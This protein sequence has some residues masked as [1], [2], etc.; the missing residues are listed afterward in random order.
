M[1]NKVL[2][3]GASGGL[4]R[5]VFQ[6]FQARY[7]TVGLC[8]S[9]T[10]GN[11]LSLDLTQPEPI[12]ELLGDL[13]PE[14]VINTVGLTDVDGCDRDIRRA[15]AVNVHTAL[16]VRQAAEGVGAKVIHFS[17]NDVFDGQK[18]MYTETDLPQPVNMYAWT[19]YMAEQMFYR[20]A[21]TLILRATIMSWFVSGKTS[22]VSWLYRSLSQGQTISLFTDQFNSPM[23]VAT[24]AAWMEQM[25]DLTGVFHLGSE[26][27]SRYGWGVRL[28]EKLG[29]DT[30]LIQPGTFAQSKFLA[31]RPVDV[32]LD[33]SRLKAATGLSTT[34]EQELDTLI[35]ERP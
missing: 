19:K 32:S 14:L 24:I 3:T 15:L 7:D 28:A 29:F 6:Y 11:H 5:A 17:T 35:V 10:N 22:F 13:R 16:H 23:Y 31:P 9:Q 2:I 30:C 1:V 20:Y 25:T 8:H 21:N 34:L 26:R 4:G 18:G 33:S 12:K 27:Y